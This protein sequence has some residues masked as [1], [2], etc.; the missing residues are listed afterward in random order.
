MNRYR[1]KV[2]SYVV[3]EAQNQT[4]AKAKA[5]I[6]HRKAI[7]HWYAHNQTPPFLADGWELYGWQ[8]KKAERVSDDE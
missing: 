6:A 4:R 5:E 1:V 2:E 3:V 8:A 7:A